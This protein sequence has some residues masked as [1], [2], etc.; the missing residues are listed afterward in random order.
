MDG[1]LS[2]VNDSTSEQAAVDRDV[3][4]LKTS[5][6]RMKRMNDESLTVNDKR[7]GVCFMTLK[8]VKVQNMAKSED[9]TVEN[10]RVQ[11]SY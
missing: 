4:L 11:I 9:Y 10:V 2:T 5:G 1:D 6:G 7:R 8:Q 3:A